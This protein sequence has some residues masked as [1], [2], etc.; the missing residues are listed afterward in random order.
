MAPAIHRPERCST[1]ST[2]SERPL[3]RP[4]S[5]RQPAERSVDGAFVIPVTRTSNATYNF[6]LAQTDR[7]GNASIAILFQWVRDNTIPVTRALT[8]PSSSPYYAAGTSLTI[9][10]TC[11][12]GLSVKLTGA[13]TATQSCGGG[14]FSFHVSPAS[15]GSFD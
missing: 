11:T 14:V 6:H 13:S 5:D 8:A 2:L 7:A 3:S 9:A 12:S 15:D 1:A 4:R 10:G